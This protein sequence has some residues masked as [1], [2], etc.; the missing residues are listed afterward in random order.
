MTQTAIPDKNP[1]RLLTAGYGLALTIPA[2]MLVCSHLFLGQLS[3]GQDSGAAFLSAR[4]E[5]TA[6]QI[7]LQATSF[8]EN[9][10]PLT[11]QNLSDAIDLLETSH[12]TLL[13]GNPDM[14]ISG[15]MGAEV[16]RVFF[17]PPFTLDRK[18]NAFLGEARAF[19]AETPEAMTPANPH[20]RYIMG[21]AQGALRNAFDA[22]SLAYEQERTAQAVRAQSFQNY[23]L[24]VLLAVLGAEALFLFRPLTRRLADY[25]E[26]LRRLAARDGLTSVDTHETFVQKGTKELR[27]SLR[28]GKPLSVCLVD[29][30]HFKSLNDQYGTAVGDRVLCR[31]TEI[32]R[33][34]MRLE[35]ELGRMGGSGNGTIFEILMPQTR[36]SEA[37]RVA[38]RLRKT[39][40]LS[41]IKYADE[42][43][44]FMTVSLG[45][46]EASTKSP[47]LDHT[48]AAAE[49]MLY[50]AKRTGRNKVGSNTPLT[51]LTLEPV[52]SLPVEFERKH[53]ASA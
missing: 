51:A 10:N 44:L 43:D 50:K 14:K 25:T 34:A 9:Q 46:A 13:K 17:A 15:S 45:V 29:I 8:I 49:D 4:Q 23:A 3:T 32:L 33:G 22:A 20:Y 37:V 19:L 30:D 16:Q 41:P 53:M 42:K 48:L 38:E 52:D 2:L 18:L 39:I 40:E 31:L 5:Q 1:S 6:Q 7:A 21:E 28:T 11:R 47:V 12:Q 36:L 27:R 26:T 24:F 35:D